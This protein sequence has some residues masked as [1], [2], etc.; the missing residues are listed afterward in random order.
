ML[1][2]NGIEGNGSINRGLG[3]SSTSLSHVLKRLSEF[4]TANSWTVLTVYTACVNA[5]QHPEIVCIG[6]PTREVL[7]SWT[8]P[9]SQPAINIANVG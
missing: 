7:L 1:Q 5:I 6:M 9:V 8:N 3:V 4:K 2:I